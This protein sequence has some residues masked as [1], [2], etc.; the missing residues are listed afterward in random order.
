MSLITDYKRSVHS[1]SLID[2]VSTII[3]CLLAIVPFPIRVTLV[4]CPV[5]D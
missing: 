3:L 2:V 5:P 1:L 4:S